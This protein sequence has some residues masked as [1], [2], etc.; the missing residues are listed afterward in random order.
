MRRLL[1]VWLCIYPEEE[2]TVDAFLLDF[3][4]FALVIGVAVWA[5]IRL[6]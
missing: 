3:A 6:T 1:D 2:P 5:I 4:A